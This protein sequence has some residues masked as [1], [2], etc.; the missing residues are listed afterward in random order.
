MDEQTDLFADAELFP[1]AA[2]APLPAIAG[3]YYIGTSGYVFPDWRGTVYPAHLSDRELLPHY[4]N[5]WKFNALEI[6]VTFYRMP[7]ARMLAS[8]DERTPPDYQLAIKVFREL[9][10][11]PHTEA[12]RAQAAE[13]SAALQPL[14]DSGKLAALLFQFPYSFK[15]TRENRD[16]LRVCRA[17]FPAD[18]LVVEFRNASWHTPE[19]DELL[20]ELDCAYCA[21]DEPQLRGLVPFHDAVTSPLG[22]AR[23]HGRNEHW[24]TAGEKERYNY[25]YSDR[26]LRDL[27]T[28]I[29]R[30]AEQTRKMLIFFNN[31][32]MG[33]A[34]KNAM[35]MRQLVVKEGG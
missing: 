34:V 17:L 13:M 21:V 14:R 26:E 22:Y 31:C 3:N 16:Y 20:R 24:F 7:T 27:F 5:V 9:T 35:H 11:V 23:L 25:D 18:P 15:H 1:E 33:R 8:F 19:T 28:R 4:L 29:R 12:P 2:P 6:N 10:H 30:M 32:Y